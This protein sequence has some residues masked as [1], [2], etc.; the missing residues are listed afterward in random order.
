MTYK[1]KSIY[2]RLKNKLH[3]KD[4]LNIENSAKLESLMN[5]VM[6]LRKVCNHPELFQIQQARQPFLFKSHLHVPNQFQTM[7]N[8]LAGIVPQIPN[9]KSGCENPIEFKIS[10][11]VYDLI[12][13]KSKFV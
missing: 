10:K 7:S 12:I 4:L 13:C 1:Q 3:F 8:Q 11:M 6:Q 5:L 9:I 2:Q